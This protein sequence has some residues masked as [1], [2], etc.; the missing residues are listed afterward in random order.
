MINWIGCDFLNK[1]IKCKLGD[2]VLFNPK[3][4]LKKGT[5][6]KKVPMDILKPFC[7]DI[8]KF[9]W[10][11]F[12]GGTKF[13]NGDTIMARIT[14][15]LE[16]GKTAKVNI[17]EDDE[18]GF[19]STE[20]IV[21]RAI[22]G[23]T[24]EDFV[25]YLVCSPIVRNPAIK[26]MVGSSG[27]QRVQ[28]DVLQNLE[29]CMPD[30]ETQHKIGS[31]LKSL[32]DKIALNTAINKNLDKQMQT[33][34]LNFISAKTTSIQTTVEDVILT[35][36]TGADAIQKAPIV[37]YNTGIRCVR[38]GDMT[39]NRSFYDWEYAKVT[40]DVF[41]R[42][43]L[44]KDDIIVT[45]T[46]SLG[47][48]AIIS[49]D[50]QA[51]YNNGLIR[52]IVNDNFVLPLFLYRQFQTDD[53]SNYIARIE[54]ETSVRPNMKINYL[55]KYTFNLPTID[56]QTKLINLLSPMI[57]QQN[58]FNIENKRLEKIK[59]TLLPKLISGELDFFKIEI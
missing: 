44:H 31:L 37:D 19:G 10:T 7:R 50:L 3:E 53:F 42:Y 20:Y 43:Q 23:I 8:S 14:P 52:L 21:F 59:N 15:C 58:V 18:V 17:L 46:A 5:I 41:K 51:V 45:R 35:A 48:N 57:K 27:R 38:V 34:F 33:I 22:K 54:C 39:N 16:N 25:Y 30:L 28:T 36:N 11:E 6:A 13:R 47:L 32:D 40:D 24:D 2:A 12:S 9:E 1:W 49:D 26:S 29:I 56:E 4:S 55:L